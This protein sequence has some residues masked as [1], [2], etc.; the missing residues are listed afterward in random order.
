MSRRFDFERLI[1]LCW[2]THEEARRSAVQA[3]ERSLVVRKRLVGW[4]IVEY[5]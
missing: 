4:Y 2:L 1:E 5:E 3:A